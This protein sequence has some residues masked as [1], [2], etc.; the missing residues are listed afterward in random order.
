[1]SERYK[2]DT[3]GA[4]VMNYKTVLEITAPRSTSTVHIKAVRSACITVHAKESVKNAS[5]APC[6]VTRIVVSLLSAVCFYY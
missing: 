3:E 5:M 1:M 6:N 4:T 2:L